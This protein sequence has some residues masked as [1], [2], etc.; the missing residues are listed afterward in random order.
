MRGWVLVASTAVALVA[1]VVAIVM[2][3]ARTAPSA[4]VAAAVYGALVAG[5]VSIVLAG[6]GLVERWIERTEQSRQNTEARVFETLHYF[7]GGSQARNV[8]IAVLETYWDDPRLRQ[9]RDLCVP[10]LANQAMYLLRASK[11]ED[12]AHEQDNLR[13]MIELLRKASEQHRFPA[14]YQLVQSA[15]REKLAGEAGGVSVSDSALRKWLDDLD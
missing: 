12:K 13:R 3:L 6:L 9:L 10:L 14:S 8:G 1:A 2:G 15:L 5:V 4:T 11:Q 7:Q